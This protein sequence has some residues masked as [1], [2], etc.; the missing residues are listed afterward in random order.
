MS[1]IGFQDYLNLQKRNTPNQFLYGIAFTLCI[2]V[3]TKRLAKYEQEL[4]EQRFIYDA[5]SQQPNSY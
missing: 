2:K 5:A 3:Y 4:M 1:F